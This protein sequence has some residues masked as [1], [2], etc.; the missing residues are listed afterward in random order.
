MR[1]A[2]TYTDDKPARYYVDGVRVSRERFEF[3]EILCQQEGKQYNSSYTKCKQ[4]GN[5][6][7][8]RTS[9]HSYS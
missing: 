5:G 6:R 9:Y 1:F 4:L 3:K 7:L 2:T 8:R